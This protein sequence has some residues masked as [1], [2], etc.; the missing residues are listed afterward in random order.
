MKYLEMVLTEELTLFR[1]RKNYSLP[2]CYKAGF[3]ANELIRMTAG[4]KITS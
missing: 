3:E 4:V 1:A 2:S